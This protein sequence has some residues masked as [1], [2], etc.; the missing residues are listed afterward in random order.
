MC[1]CGN[2]MYVSLTAE[3]LRSEG[4]LDLGMVIIETSEY[5][6]YEDGDPPGTVLDG[7]DVMMVIVGAASHT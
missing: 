4:D 6:N 2:V 7:L 1:P 5:D 3:D